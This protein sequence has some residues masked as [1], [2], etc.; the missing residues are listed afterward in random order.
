M[1]R[2]DEIA[3]RLKAATPG[4]W[5]Y[6]PDTCNVDSEPNAGGITSESWWLAKMEPDTETDAVADGEFIA[7]SR[8]DIEYLT[9]RLAVLS[10]ALAF[11]ADA[12]NW[13][14]PSTGLAAEYDRLPSPIAADG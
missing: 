1:S 4:P 3:A 12:A 7:H 10:D 13:K 9:A 2:M 11:Y 8:S 14:S 6:V 5:R